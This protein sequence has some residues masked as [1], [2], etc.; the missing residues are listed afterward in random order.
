M[1]KTTLEAL[2]DF[3]MKRGDIKVVDF[4]GA[5]RMIQSN[6]PDALDLVERADRLGFVVDPTQEKA[7]QSFSMI[8]ARDGL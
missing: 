1:G 2:T 4:T 5:R 6:L 7:L 3:L 8:S